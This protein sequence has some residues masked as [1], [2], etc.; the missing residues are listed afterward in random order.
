M[1]LDYATLKITWW[2]VMCFITIAFAVT[3]GLDIGVNFLIPI[4]GK[5]DDERRMILNSIGATWEGN[6]VWLITLGAGMFA[7]WPTAYATAFS[8][9]YFA[10]FLAIFV[11]IL[12]PPSN[13]YRSK[14]KS[15]LWRYTWDFFLFSS[16]VVLAIIFGVGIGN[17]FIGIPFYFDSNMHSLYTG[18]FLTLLSPIAIWFG[19]VSLLMC[20]LQGSIFL[21]YKLEEELAERVKKMVRLTGL[22]FITAFIIAGFIACNMHG[23]KILDTPD[24]NTGFAAVEKTVE[25]VSNGWLRNYSQY[26]MLWLLPILVVFT[27]LIAMLLSNRNK[28]IAALFA[29]SIAIICT[30]LTAASALFPFIVPSSLMPNHSLTIWDA[31]SSHF[32]LEWSLYATILILPMVLLYTSW[33][34]KVMRGKVQLHR[35]SY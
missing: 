20:T 14:I 28:A 24:L 15:T 5:N 19:L 21:Q 10:L 30:V 11:L 6:Q 31:C 34:Y 18:N 13:D 17:L 35:E 32:T 23:Y 12:R 16:G 33:V 4:L 3:G 9:L 2:G 29:N 25:H 8:S 7:I 1:L 26:S 27:T 22:G